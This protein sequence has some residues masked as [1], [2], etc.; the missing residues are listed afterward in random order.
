ME[1]RPRPEVLPRHPPPRTWTVCVVGGVDGS[2]PSEQV[3]RWC[4]SLAAVAD[5]EVVAVYAL[6][7]RSYPPQFRH[8]LPRAADRDHAGWRAAVAARTDRGSG[9][10]RH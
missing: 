7:E 5:L 10:T 2:A 9:G 3:L 6:E 4:A 1:A 8:R